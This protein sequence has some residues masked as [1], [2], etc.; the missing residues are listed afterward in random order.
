MTVFVGS[1]FQDPAFGTL[2][3]FMGFVILFAK[4]GVR[5]VISALDSHINEVR[6]SIDKAEQALTQA[7]QSL[8]SVNKM[9]IEQKERR[10]EMLR[11]AHARSKIIFQQMKQQ[12]EN[13]ERA[14]AAM[15]ETQIDAMTRSLRLEVTKSLLREAFSQVRAV[16]SKQ[17]AQLVSVEFFSNEL[18]L[19]D[20]I[21]R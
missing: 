15:V 19:I 1:F 5:S 17:D 11:Y 16:V 3:A 2:L 7:E 8:A 20:K 12:L 9:A 14:R 21:S 4:F 6:D 18:D 13:V 10:E